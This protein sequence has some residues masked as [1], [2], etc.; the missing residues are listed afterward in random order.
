[1]LQNLISKRLFLALSG[2]PVRLK[3]VFHF[4]EQNI[5]KPVKDE[6]NAFFL[7]APLSTKAA[8]FNKY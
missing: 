6:G 3:N 7:L 2:L 8:I 4:F 5:K 1:M